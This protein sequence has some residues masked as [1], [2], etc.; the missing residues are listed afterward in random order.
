[1]NQANLRVT[2]LAALALFL[3]LVLSCGE[4][5]S[6][7]SPIPA[8]TGLPIESKVIVL[9]NQ[10]G[11]MEGHTPMGFPGMGTGLFAGDNLNPRFPEGD[12]VQ[13]FLTFDLSALPSGKIISALLSSDR[14]SVSGTPMKDLGPLRA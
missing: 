1:M 3:L 4:G 5:S 8:A 6:G 2:F 9:Q 11:G 12:G 7:D 10:G 14:A 13:L